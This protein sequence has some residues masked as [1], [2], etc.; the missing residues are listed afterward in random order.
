MPLKP[1]SKTPV[2]LFTGFLGSGKTTLLNRILADPAFA[3][4]A[5]IINEFGDISIDHLLVATP[6]E[7]M[8]VLEQL[9]R[10]RL[11]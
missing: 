5:V 11:G 7:N 4:S 9:D 10:V 2:T 8:F 3:D 1:V 6:R